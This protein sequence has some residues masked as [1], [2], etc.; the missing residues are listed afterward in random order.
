MKMRF[1]S[2][3]LVVTLLMGFAGTSL[4]AAV[5]PPLP[6]GEVVV[7]LTEEEMEEIDGAWGT[8]AAA[9]VIGAAYGGAVYWA[10]TPPA[11][12]NWSDGIKTCAVHAVSFFLGSFF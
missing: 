12:R 8:H 4:A 3:F 5:S 2:L 10:D 9:A 6:F 1:I 11:E 7:P